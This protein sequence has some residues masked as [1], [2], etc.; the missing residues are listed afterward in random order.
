MSS[1]RAGTQE[2]YYRQS[3]GCA[4]SRLPIPVANIRCLRDQATG[5]SLDVALERRGDGYQLT[6]RSGGPIL[7]VQLL[8]LEGQQVRVTDIGRVEA[9][10]SLSVA[11]PSRP[12]PGTHPLFQEPSAEQIYSSFSYGDD[13]LEARPNI[14]RHALARV[15]DAHARTDGLFAWL[16]SGAL[17]LWAEVEPPLDFTLQDE[18]TEN[19]HLQLHRIVFPKEML[20]GA[21]TAEQAPASRAARSS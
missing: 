7:K 11:E 18:A 9:G 10:A 3:A 14:P 4:I 17:L 15:G 12:A 5:E 6:N 20:D 16:K 13:N 8:R 21:S 1:S 2:V 19:F